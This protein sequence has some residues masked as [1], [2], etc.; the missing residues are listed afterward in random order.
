MRSQRV[1]PGPVAGRLRAPPSKS[2]TH[3][4]LV[5]AYLS[6]GRSTIERPLRSA[7]TIATA[8]ALRRLGARVST[9]SDRWTVAPGSGAV[10][11]RATINCGES[12]TTLRFTSALAALKAWTTRFEGKGRLPERPMGVLVRALRSLGARVDT[13]ARSRGLPMTITGPIHG[14]GVRVDASESSQFVSALLLVLPTIRPAS[15][16]WM[17]GDPVSAPYI[18]ATLAVLAEHGVHVGR[19][20]RR[21]DIPGGQEFS[22]TRYVVPGDASSAAYLWAAAAISGGSTTVSGVETSWPQ[23]DL[24]ILDLLVRYGATVRRSA[25]AITVTAG[26][27][28]PFRVSLTDC[29][30]LYPLAGVLAAAAPGP[31]RLEGAPQVVAKESDRR[32]ETVRLAR[33]MGARVVPTGQCLLIEGTAHPRPLSVRGAHDHRVVMSAAVGA[34]AASGPSVISDA[35]S[36][37]KSFPEFWTMLAAITGEERMR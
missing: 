33:A 29:P 12:G 14:G 19:R 20:G 21:F 25:R 26:R 7:D 11:R 2:Y 5:A 24:A 4:A 34:L 9:R 3:R 36:V 27:R 30:D 37:G 31:S 32:Q 8:E 18:E 23:A 10:P 15:T 35:A 28:Q 22:G 6:H 1:F 16:L 17:A 13:P